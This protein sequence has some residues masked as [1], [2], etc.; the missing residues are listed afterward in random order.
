MSV[1]TVIV[2]AQTAAGQRERVSVPE[3]RNTDA[4]SVDT[5]LSVGAQHR[6][7]RSHGQRGVQSE[8]SRRQHS[9]VAG[10]VA[11]DAGRARPQRETLHVA[12]PAIQHHQAPARHH[13]NIRRALNL[14]SNI[15]SLLSHKKSSRYKLRETTWVF[16]HLTI[17]VHWFC[18]QDLK[19]KLVCNLIFFC[20]L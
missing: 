20:F 3:R 11:A 2:P 4:G 18:I 1:G 14:N 15:Q 12:P 16:R 17:F 5:G 8:R 7:G 6:P 13:W 9:H 19:F 10:R